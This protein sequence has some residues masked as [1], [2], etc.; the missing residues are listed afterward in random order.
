MSLDCILKVL[1]HKGGSFSAMKWKD[2]CSFSFF[3]LQ[4]CFFILVLGHTNQPNLD[5]LVKS[6]FNNLLNQIWIKF[7]F[8]V[9]T[10]IYTLYHCV[11]MWGCC[12]CQ[13]NPRQKIKLLIDN[14]ITSGCLVPVA[15]TSIFLFSNVCYKNNDE[16]SQ[17]Y[18]LKCLHWNIHAPLESWNQLKN[19]GC[20]MNRVE[21]I[22]WTWV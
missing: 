2:I 8:N 13:R 4:I 14:S 11:L 22:E 18:M 12:A 16:K 10:E 21:E 9:L 7:L 5:L 1:Y 19:C 6:T 3:A 15:K 17:C 20:C